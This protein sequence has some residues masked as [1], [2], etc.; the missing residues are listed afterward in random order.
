MGPLE[1]MTVIEIASLGPGPFCAMVLADLGAKVIRVDRQVSGGQLP[2]AVDPL[3]RGRE[4]LTLDLKRPGS[5][6]VVLR[7]VERADVLL[8]GFR[9]GVAERLGIGPDACLGRNPRLVYGR[10]TGWGQEGP[11]AARAGHD[12]DYIALAGALYPIGRAG[13]PPVPPLNLVADFGG[14][15]M[16]AALGVLAALWERQRSGLGQVVD[17]AMVDGS[18]LLT[19]MFHGMR[20]AG[21]WTDDRGTNLLDSGAPFYDCYETADGRFVAVGALEPQFYVALCAGLGLDPAT[22]PS[23]Y[24]PSGWPAL[25]E[26]LAAAFRTRTR[27]EWEEVF[28]GMDACVAPVLT[29]E[30][31]TH[32]PHNLARGTFVQVGG[33]TQPGPAPRFGRTP[34]VVPAPVAVPGEHTARVLADFGFT[35]EEVAGLRA[36]LVVG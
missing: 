30:E 34:A 12:I 19:A 10:V 29:M 35:E 17:A 7:L 5:A 31:A 16:L 33:I 2:I 26:R 24:D 14:G 1:G 4:S 20:A 3:L 32:H 18:A 13:G 36:A 21:L 28:G 27:D 8:E 6:E 23:Q 11:L 25:R 22:L 9:P 15:G